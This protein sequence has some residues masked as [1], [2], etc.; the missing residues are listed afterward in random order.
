MATIL[1][2]ANETLGSHTLV[3]A[4]RRRHEQGEAHFVL[5]A[6]QNKATSG[7]VSYN[8][9]LR[10]AAQARID[11]TLAF[12]SEHGIDAEGEVFDPDPYSAVLDATAE[13]RPS[14]IIISTHPASRSGWL[15]Q[16]LVE[17]VRAG[18]G[19]RVE[20]VVTDLE[21]E[22]D[23]AKHTLVVANQTA[24]TPA[25]LSHLRAKAAEAPRHFIAVVPQGGKD[26]HHLVESRDRLL[27]LLD[28]LRE[29]GFQA[30]GS[31]GDPDPFTAIMNALSFYRV[32]EIV[33]STLP[34]TRSGWLRADLVERVRRA[35]SVPVEHVVAEREPVDAGQEARA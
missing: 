17:R 11:M 28:E 31:V 26:G 12:L 30:V 13:F 1:V 16:D 6:P 33:I 14:E 23:G 8:E 4:V 24:E 10:D 22:R 18:T 27:A 35:T 7:L 9:V 25:L 32:D 29:E 20:H 3:D 15:G 21:A 5:V 2:V 34:A 19:L